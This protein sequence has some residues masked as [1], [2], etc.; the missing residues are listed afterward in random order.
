MPLGAVDA[1][2]GSGHCA[3]S[4]TMVRLRDQYPSLADAVESVELD[5]LGDAVR[6]VAT[7]A[8]DAC[9]LT[10][11]CRGALDHDRLVS[12]LDEAAWVAQESGDQLGYDRAFRRARAADAWVRSMQV[13]DRE[14]A[15]EAI[16]EAVH[17]LGGGASAERTIVRLLGAELR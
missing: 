9:Q 16:Y 2:A 14:A 15:S 6:V 12:S 1:L 3:V 7:A 5:Q 11:V 17:A 4:V 10:E 8:T 13:D